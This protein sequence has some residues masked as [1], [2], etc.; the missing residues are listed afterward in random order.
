MPLTTMNRPPEWTRPLLSLA[1]ALALAACG[2]GT[3]GTGT[4]PGASS[5]LANGTYAAAGDMT[6]PV[7]LTV[8]DERVELNLPCGR[9]VHEGP[10]SFDAQARAELTGRW[11]QLVQAGAGTVVQELSARLSLQAGALEGEARQLQVAVTDPVGVALVPP[12]L[13]A[14]QLQEAPAISCLLSYSFQ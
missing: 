8:S 7:A 10:W 1:L 14:P 9:F 6:V 2:P 5:D 11:Q 12:V 13:L 4:G 3:G